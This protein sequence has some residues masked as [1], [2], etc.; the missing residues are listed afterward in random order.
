MLLSCYFKHK[1]N[2]P[3]MWI[4]RHLHALNISWTTASCILYA[5]LSNSLIK[6]ALFHSYHGWVF[7]AESVSCSLLLLP[8]DFY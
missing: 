1:K 3:K 5:K 4:Y 8:S 2:P 6:I 7:Q